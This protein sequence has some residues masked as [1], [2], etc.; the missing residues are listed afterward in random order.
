MKLAR[1]QLLDYQR[2]RKEEEQYTQKLRAAG[3]SEDIT[4]QNSPS[5]LQAPQLRG[6]ERMPA[7]T[8][9]GVAPGPVEWKL[10]YVERLDR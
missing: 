9:S 1:L 8:L 7:A 3:I 2:A 4:T 5:P 10:K 6:A